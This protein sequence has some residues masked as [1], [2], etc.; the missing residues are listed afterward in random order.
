MLDYVPAPACLLDGDG[1]ISEANR[2]WQDL[3]SRGRLLPEGGHRVSYL[4]LCEQLGEGGQSLRD[5]VA[6]VLAGEIDSVTVEIPAGPVGQRAYRFRVTAASRESGGAASLVGF[7]TRRTAEPRRMDETSLQAQKLEAVGRLAGGVAH[8]FNNLLTLI[9]GYTEILLARMVPGDVNRPE[10]EEIRKAANRGSSLTEQLLHFSR[11]QKVEPRIID[12]NQL[13]SDMERMLRRMIGEDVQL[14]AELAV[15]LG[16]IR[17]DPG[18]TGQVLM[19][20]A[21]NA[22]D[23]MPRGGEIRIRTADVTITP[24]EAAAR[25]TLHAGAYVMLTLEDNGEGMTEETRQRL[26]E[27]FYTTKAPGKGT[28]LGLST[29]YGIVKQSGGDIWVDSREG[30]GAKFTIL[31]PQVDDAAEPAAAPRE[32]SAAA[33]AGTETVLVVEDEPSVRRLLKH[34]LAKQGYRVLEAADGVEAVEVYRGHYAPIH[35]LLTD[36]VMPRMNGRELAD[37]LC[38]QQPD[39]KVLYISGYTDDVL[40]RNGSLGAGMAF[41][42]KPVKPQVLAVK[43]REVLDAPSSGAAMSATVE[44]E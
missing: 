40:L 34:I 3:V 24:Q 27:P 44:L 10:I 31:L 5:G 8:D 9:C 29:V 37:Y 7:E 6:G 39:L 32:G 22:R 28:G 11:R 36:M 33:R 18:Q 30:Q 26:F 4:T 14:T 13:V 2:E 42:Q 12:L 38:A 41:L 1:V 23:A 21:L 15:G 35:L 16:K 25:P 43:V 17:A 19:N 20:L